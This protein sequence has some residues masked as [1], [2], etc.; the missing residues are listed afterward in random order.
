MGRDFHAVTHWRV[1][2]NTWEM[3]K[4]AIAQWA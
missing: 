4:V 2:R 1:K 3:L